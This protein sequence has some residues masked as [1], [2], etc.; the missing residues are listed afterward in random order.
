VVNF[1]SKIARVL[2]YEQKIHNKECRQN[3]KAAL[4][5]NS[6]NSKRDKLYEFNCFP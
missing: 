3:R 5:L 1:P 6:L 2:F 4:L